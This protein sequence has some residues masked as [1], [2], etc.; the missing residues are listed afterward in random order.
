MR[1]YIANLMLAISRLLC[2]LVGGLDGEPLSSHAHMMRQRHRPTG[3]F[4]DWID[5]VARTVFRDANH[6]YKSNLAERSRIA[7]RLRRDH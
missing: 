7:S 2:A 1:D 3:R 4:A 6:C 5:G